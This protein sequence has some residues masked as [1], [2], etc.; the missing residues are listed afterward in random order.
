MN[1]AQKKPMVHVN[2]RLPQEVVDFYKQEP[3][4]TKAMR[5]AL[6]K[7]MRM[8]KKIQEAQDDTTGSD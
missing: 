7:V 2:V 6:A 4:Y 5:E 8:K 3:N 1:E